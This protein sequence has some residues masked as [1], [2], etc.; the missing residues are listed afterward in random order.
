MSL[1]RKINLIILA[2]ISILV[3]ALK[4]HLG[5]ESSGFLCQ[6]VAISF[7]HRDSDLGLQALVT[8]KASWH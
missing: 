1:R 5:L 7:I 6:P 8:C 4:E 3:S 2:M